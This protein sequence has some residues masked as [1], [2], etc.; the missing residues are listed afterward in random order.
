[1]HRVIQVLKIKYH[2]VSLINDILFV[3]QNS[4]SEKPK[5]LQRGCRTKAAPQ[6]EEKHYRKVSDSIANNYSPSASHLTTSYIYN[7]YKNRE[8]AVF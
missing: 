1:M 6:K 3:I 7:T 8:Y 4:F 5:I 2:F